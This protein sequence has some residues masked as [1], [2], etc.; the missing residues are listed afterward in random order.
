[1]QNN[2]PSFDSQETGLD[3]FELTPFQSKHTSRKAGGPC[4]LTIVKT[5]KNGKRITISEEVL[6]R[7]GATE[8]VQLASYHG[9]I[10]IGRELPG[11][12]SSPYALKKSGKKGVVYCGPLVEELTELFGLDFSGGRTSISFHEVEYLTKDGLPM[13]FV[14]LRQAGQEPEVEPTS[15]EQELEVEISPKEQE[16]NLLEFPSPLAGISSDD[17]LDPPQEA[18][19]E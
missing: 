1:M 3:E 7:I 14:P 19:E 2:Q 18:F 13:A 9:G 10:A 5:L 4:N 17:E 12:G 11:V 6:E 16:T 15:T 8:T